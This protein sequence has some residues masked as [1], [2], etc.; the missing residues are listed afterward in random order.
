MPKQKTKRAA[1]KRFSI[2]GTGKIKRSRA[3]K[4][5]ILTKK[6]TKRKNQ[7]GKSTLVSSADFPRTI[8]LLQA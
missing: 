1:M 6:T 4:R 8:K 5:H 3:N 7:L 2:T